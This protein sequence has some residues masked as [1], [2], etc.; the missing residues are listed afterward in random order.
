MF[1]I[2]I[3]AFGFGLRQ[4]APAE[5]AVSPLH[6]PKR[7]AYSTVCPYVIK[8]PPQ[9][10]QY[11]GEFHGTKSDAWTF[12]L[13]YA[14]LGIKASAEERIFNY[15]DNSMPNSNKLPSFA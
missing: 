5:D 7:S 2:R 11:I 12:N 13:W 8:S 6:C 3:F 15:N 4:Y 10:A 14:R 9:I 1:E